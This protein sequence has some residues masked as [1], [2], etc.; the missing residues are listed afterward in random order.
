ML[1]AD[2]GSRMVTGEPLAVNFTDMLQSL[3][4]LCLGIGRL[5]IEIQ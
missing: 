3:L 1:V 4:T 5:T 2:S